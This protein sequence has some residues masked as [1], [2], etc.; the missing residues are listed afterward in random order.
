MESVGHLSVA[1]LCKK[2]KAIG[3]TVR[4]ARPDLLAR[5]E[6]FG[7]SAAAPSLVSPSSVARRCPECHRLLQGRAGRPSPGPPGLKRWE[8]KQCVLAKGTKRLRKHPDRLVPEPFA[9]DDDSSGC[10][11]GISL[12]E[13]SGSI[14]ASDVEWMAQLEGGPKIAEFGHDAVQVK[15]DVDRVISIVDSD[16]EFE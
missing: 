15:V 16:G 14:D 3:C 8:L 1:D 4:G 5:L 2:C 11:D 7:Y 13:D 10:W 6:K 9:P 12:D